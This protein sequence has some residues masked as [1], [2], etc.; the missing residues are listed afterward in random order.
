MP[1]HATHLGT[2]CSSS[3]RSSSIRSRGL[4]LLL[5]SQSSLL[6]LLQSQSSL[7]PSSP[8]PLRLAQ[9]HG[10]HRLLG[11]GSALLLRGLCLLRALL[12]LF[13]ACRRVLLAQVQHLL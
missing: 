11:L 5:Q 10:V 12:L 1:H 13:A 9:E 6:L 7:L 4:L 2:D 3:I 8:L